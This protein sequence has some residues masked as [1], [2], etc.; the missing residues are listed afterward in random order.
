MKFYSESMKDIYE[1]GEGKSKYNSK[2]LVQSMF[3]ITE[4]N[5]ISVTIYCFHSSARTRNS[6]NKLHFY[7]PVKRK[8][9][10]CP[11]LSINLHKQK[12]NGFKVMPRLRNLIR[13]R[14]F[15][16]SNVHESNQHFP[17]KCT[18]IQLIRS[19]CFFF[20]CRGAGCKSKHWFP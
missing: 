11:R 8:S 6:K 20:V 2:N 12:N 7:R 9:T 3:N 10:V 15:R 16:K 18:E 5:C 19:G 13:P 1:G 4:H 17:L 14:R